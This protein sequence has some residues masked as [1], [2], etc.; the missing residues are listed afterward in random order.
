MNRRRRLRRLMADEKLLRRRAAGEP[1]RQ[2]AGEYDV[3]HTTLCRYFARPE[4]KEQLKKVVSQLRAEQRRLTARRAAE[5]RLE[6]QVRRR[7]EEQAAAEA[8][9]ARRYRANLA[10]WNSGRR[11]SGSG[12]AAWLDERDAPWLP[13]TRADRHST[14]DKE[15]ERTVTAG[16]GTQALLAATELPTLEAAADSIDPELLAQAFDNDALERAQP[17]PL[18]LTGRPRLRRLVADTQLLRRRAAGEP[19]RMLAS[20]YDVAHTTLARFLARPEIKR[21]LRQTVQELRAE[22]RARTVRRSP[23]GNPSRHGALRQ[24]PRR[25]RAASASRRS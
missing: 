15:A 1:L 11:A 2:L 3:A 16:G 25:R 7:A 19:L 10:A 18:A 9:Q 23:G 20:D 13:P 17:Q 5:R 14:Y 12:H 21:Q 6:R 22:R 4:V 24:P 8:E